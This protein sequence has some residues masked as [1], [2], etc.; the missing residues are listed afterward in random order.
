MK[1]NRL[2]YKFGG[3]PESHSDSSRKEG[4][5]AKPKFMFEGPI[6][7]NQEISR[8]KNEAQRAKNEMLLKKEQQQKDKDKDD[9]AALLASIEDVKMPEVP[10][11]A[12]VDQSK[13]KEKMREVPIIDE[14]VLASDGSSTIGDLKSKIKTSGADYHNAL[15][16]LDPNKS[17]NILVTDKSGNERPAMWMGD[18]YFYVDS[19]DSK[20]GEFTDPVVL[21]NYGQYSLKPFGG[22]TPLQYA[23][24]EETPMTVAASETENPD[25]AA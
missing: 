20:A 12:E 25:K 10:K 23:E 2:V 6:G 5:L 13:K 24:F 4:E 9:M 15:A 19:F 21:L 8:I 18:K 11:A 1:E 17:Q 3:A 14:V 22:E 16:A 7:S